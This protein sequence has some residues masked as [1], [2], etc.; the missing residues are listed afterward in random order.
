MSAWVAAQRSANQLWPHSTEENVG[1]T[2]L[3]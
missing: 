1:S 3:T 2:V